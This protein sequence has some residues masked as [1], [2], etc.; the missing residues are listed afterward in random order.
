MAVRNPDEVF[1]TPE[2]LPAACR[3]QLHAEAVRGIALFNAGEYWEAHEALETAW[4]EERGPARHLYKGILQ[5]GVM[6]LQIQRGNYLGMAKM[7]ERCKKWLRPWPPVCRGVNVDQLRA[8]VEAAISEARRLGPER[9][10]EFDT[11]LL[12]PVELSD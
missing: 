10:G 6:Y 11:A 3:G 7:Y 12:K 8:D 5:A 1:V 2:Q 4:K 9:L